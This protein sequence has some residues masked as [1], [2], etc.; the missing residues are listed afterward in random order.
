M[1]MI[2][3]IILT[4]K[5]FAIIIMLLKLTFVMIHRNPTGRTGFAGRGL[6]ALWG[7]NH[8]N[9]IVLTRL[10]NAIFIVHNILTT[11]AMM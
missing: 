1:R 9:D 4:L 6:L 8:A 2:F 3:I 5:P 11:H 10:V 7:P